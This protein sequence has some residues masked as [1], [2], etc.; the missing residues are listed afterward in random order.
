MSDFE[1]AR[2]GRVHHTSSASSCSRLA[3]VRSPV[4]HRGLLATEEARAR[5]SRLHQALP[6]ADPLEDAP[7]AR[8]AECD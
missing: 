5:D 1:V 8:R 7:T 2:L 3:H 4:V 6:Q